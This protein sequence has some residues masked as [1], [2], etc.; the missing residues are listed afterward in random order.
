MLNLLDGVRSKEPN[1]AAKLL[2]CWDGI[3]S[4]RLRSVRL[5]VES[6]RLGLICQFTDDS[7]VEALNLNY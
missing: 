6:I 2:L 4:F 7:Y 5:R 1:V 3:R